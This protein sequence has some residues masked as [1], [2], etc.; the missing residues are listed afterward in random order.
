M[1]VASMVTGILS[2][3]TCFIPGVG[4]VLG[5]IAIATAKK[6]AEGKLPG[7]A[8]AGLVCGIVGLCVCVIVSGIAACAGL[9]VA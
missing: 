7:M 8:I 9:M 4:I 2:L 5:I 1:G 3:I 6:D